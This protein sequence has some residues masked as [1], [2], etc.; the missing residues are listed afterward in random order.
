[1]KQKRTVTAIA[2][3]ET[4]SFMATADSLGNIIL[5]DLE[6]KKIVYRLESAVTGPIDSLFFVPG[7]QL[8][9]TTSSIANSIKQFRINLDD[10]KTLLQYR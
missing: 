4:D 8:L 9:T 3:S 6:N 5:W 1:M 10:N 2:F 7:Y